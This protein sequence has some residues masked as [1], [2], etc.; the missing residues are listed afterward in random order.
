[1]K[2]LIVTY[3]L[4]Y[5]GSVAAVLN[6]FIGLLIYIAFS[7]LKPDVLWFYSVPLGNYSKIIAAAF[8]L[9][10]ALR[11]FGNWRLGRAWGVIGAMVG[12]W[13]WA[14][15]S[16]LR[17][18]NQ[19]MAWT[20]I[21]YQLKILLPVLVGITVVDSI[22]K[23]KW[24]A[25]TIVLCWGYL[26]LEFNLYYLQGINFVY[27]N[28]FAGMEEGSVS[29]GMVCSASLAGFLALNAERWWL[30]AVAGMLVLLKV[31]FVFFSMTRGG[32]LGLVAAGLISF[33][34]LPKRPKDYVL[35]LAMTLGCLALAGSDVREEFMT[36]FA[37]ENQ[38]DASAQSRVDLWIACWKEMSKYPLLGLGP[39]H[40]PL[41][42]HEY[43][44]KPLKEAHTVW[45][46]AGAELGF[47]GMLFL[48]S[49][50]GLC[51]FRLLRLIQSRSDDGVE[52]RWIRALGSMV[53]ASLAGFVVSAQ[54]ISLERLETPFHVALIGAGLLKLASGPATA[55]TDVA[56]GEAESS[57]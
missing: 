32:M 33:M 53:V 44:F 27:L 16:G 24:L 52:D 50:Y 31:H 41:V 18:P 39:D 10:W 54:F 7:I 28:G 20:Y 48:L 17:A 55:A 25:W 1:M 22:A 45:L 13:L 30:K 35:A 9:G 4:A 51:C 6:P 36:I 37:D 47:P 46:Q 40:F 14:V 3:L 57:A 11:G 43:G 42:V 5:G 15:A 38:R 21:D 34:L 12:Y 23:L 49:F 19:E 26:A 2:G 29:I 8:F 56:W